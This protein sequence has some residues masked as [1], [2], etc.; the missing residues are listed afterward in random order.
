MA[1]FTTSALKDVNNFAIEPSGYQNISAQYVGDASFFSSTGKT[2]IEITRYPVS[3]TVTSNSNP[4]E[5]CQP[6]TFTASVSSAAPFA[7]TGLLK[8]EGAFFPR[9]PGVELVGGVASRTTDMLP[10]HCPEVGSSNAAGV[11]YLGDDYN[12]RS[13][14]GSSVQNVDATTTTSTIK[15]S[16]NPSVLGNPVTFT[17]VVKAPWAHPVV[18][19]IVFTSAGIVLGT[20]DLTQGI[21]TLKTSSL[22]VGQNAITATFYRGNGNFIGSSASILQTVN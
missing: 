13:G 1:T 6:V 17:V 9:D 3:F 10:P 7:P 8:F 15:S 20:A 4:S 14:G 22:P 21:A 12:A 19:S 5:F 18:G 11:E 2:A 16:K